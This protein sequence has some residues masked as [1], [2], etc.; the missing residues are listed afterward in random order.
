MIPVKWESRD[1]IGELIAAFNVLQARVAAHQAALTESRDKLEEDVRVRTAD[2]QALNDALRDGSQSLAKAEEVAHIGHWRWH[3]GDEHVDMS[4][5]LCRLYGVDP[6]S[7]EATFK[8]IRAMYHPDD[9]Q[10]VQAAIDKSMSRDQ[11]VEFE[12]RIIR[13]D[14]QERWLMSLSQNERDDTGQVVSLFGVSQDITERKISETLLSTAKDAAES[15]NRA[16]SEFLTM[17][18]HEIRTPMNGVLGLIGLLQDTPLDSEQRRFTDMARESGEQLLQLLN[19]ILDL[20]KLEAGKIEL[21]RTDFSIAELMTGVQELLGPSARKQ[22]LWLRYESAEDVPDYVHGD[23]GRLRQVLLNLVSNA[24]KFTEKGGVNISVSKSSEVVPD[25]MRLHFE[26]TD[27]GIGIPEAKHA[28]LFQP[29]S[30]VEAS[31]AG[32]Y[33]GT[34]LGLS[35]SKKLIDLMNGKIGFQ[36]C[37]GGGSSFWFHV[38]FSKPRDVLLTLEAQTPSAPVAGSR[39]TG[40]ILLAEDSTTNAMI[41]VTML[42]KA[43]HSVDAV[44]DGL[45][46]GRGGPHTPL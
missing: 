39:G 46:V 4:D 30:Q 21:E 40:R 25:G 24:I 17:M 29:F 10:T 33:G 13:P 35:I 38:D 3:L 1:E 26:I 11:S 36:S 23:A 2:L 15:A 6:E 20:S 16:K 9:A 43:G 32:R 8:S 7:F 37:S 22:G 31:H 28:R 34:G 44:S 5:T 42:R 45:E 14:G 19:G 12:A 27:T 18:S 41:A